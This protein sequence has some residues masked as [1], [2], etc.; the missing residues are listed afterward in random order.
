MGYSARYHAA[1]LAAV[2]FALAAGILIGAEFGGDVISSTRAS[3][4]QSLAE[5]LEDSREEVDALGAELDRSEEFGSRV[6]PALV[7]EQL[8]DETIAILSLGSLSEAGVA[9][10]EEALEPAGA[11]VAAVGVVREPPRP[12]ALADLLED[13]R[14]SRVGRD[15][16][17]LG[18][19]AE[20]A[21]LRFRNGGGML[22]V[23]RG[24]L[25]SRVSGTFRGI[26]GV[27]VL[28]TELEGLEPEDAER[29]ELLEQGLL[30]GLAE[31]GLPVVGV[32]RS[33][34]EPSS[35]GVFS[36]QG[37]PTVNN[38]DEI[39]GHLAL[40]LVLQ[41]AQGNF[42]H[43]SGADGLLPDVIT[44]GGEPREALPLGAGS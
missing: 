2:F 15:S 9:Q 17:R 35:V 43:G 40:I 34:T 33:D 22:S 42:G 39:S 26:D 31:S 19:I 21:G 27:I 25:F 10:I 3:L 37:I 13:S 7:R 6:Y 23:L 11:Q 44:D 29:V 18:S 20:A 41:G 8:E 32:E 1:S 12:Q 28:R 14:F 38:V 30:T 5:N 36:E 16:G 24:E 4:E